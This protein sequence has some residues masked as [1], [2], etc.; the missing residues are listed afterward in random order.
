[1]PRT[2]V[3][4]S[5]GCPPLRAL[6]TDIL[7]LVKVVEAHARPAGA[8]KVVETWGAPDASRAIV[9]AS[10]ADR[11]ADPVLAVA[12][13]NGV[14]EL[15]NPLNGSALAAV[16]TAGSAPNDSGA[17]GDPLAALHLFARQTSDSM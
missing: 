16:K 1:M 10:L 8:A 12:R 15:L 2:T 11:A 13:R 7:G 9:A 17:E 5:S 3:V 6:T 14:V 4:E